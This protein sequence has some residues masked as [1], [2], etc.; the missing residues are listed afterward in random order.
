M[1]VIFFLVGVYYMVGEVVVG[2][3]L[4]NVFGCCFCVVW[5]YVEMDWQGG[6]EV[7]MWFV[8]VQFFL[9]VGDWYDVEQCVIGCYCEVVYYVVIG[10]FELDFVFECVVE[11]DFVIGYVVCV[12]VFGGIV[13]VDY[14]FVCV[15]DFGMCGE[16]FVGYLFVEVG[17]V[18]GF[19]CYWVYYQ[20]WVVFF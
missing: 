2:G 11:G 6:V 20:C 8:F 18:D 10:I 5:Q 13:E 12:D 7:E 16:C 17:V 3:E 1:D 14:V 4:V 15:I 9:V 19:Q